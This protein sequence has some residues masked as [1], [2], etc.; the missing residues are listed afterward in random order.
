MAS[1]R[2]GK[3]YGVGWL[4]CVCLGVLVAYGNCLGYPASTH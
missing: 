4:I 3:G 2:S 1:M